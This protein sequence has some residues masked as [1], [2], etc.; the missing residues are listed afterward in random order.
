MILISENESSIVSQ[1]GESSLDDISSPAAIPESV[2]LSVDVSMVPPMR[3]K[4]PDTSLF[5]PLS[6]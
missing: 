2:V 4:K 1:A 6:E 5:E 3:R